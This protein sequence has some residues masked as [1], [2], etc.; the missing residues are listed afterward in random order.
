MAADIREDIA[1]TSDNY[2]FS[3]AVAGL[4][5]LLRDNDQ[6]STLDY[7]TVLDLAQGARGEDEFGYRAE[8][9]QLAR[10]AQALSLN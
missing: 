10:T 5:Q 2:R 4:A 1:D 9:I 3:A 8:F 7:D 6:T